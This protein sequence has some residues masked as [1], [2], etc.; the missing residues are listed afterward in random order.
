MRKIMPQEIEIWY[1]IPALRRELT[2]VFIESHGLNQKRVAE[3]LGITEPA[4]SQYLKSKRGKEMQFSKKEIVHIQIAGKKMIE[5]EDNV[6]KIL[7]DLCV[8]FRGSKV[9]CDLHRSQD[10]SVDSKCDICLEH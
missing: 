2:K 10:S 1:L 3:I 4:V 5:D 9:I 8:V 6:M 7:Y